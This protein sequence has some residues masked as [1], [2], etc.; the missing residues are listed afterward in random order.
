MKMLL[1][2]VYKIFAE[3]GLRS[4]S[5]LY[6][7]VSTIFSPA[8]TGITI[9]LLLMSC[10]GNHLINNKD[11]LAGTE[12]AFVFKKE[13]AANRDSDLFSVF[14]QKLSNQQSEALKF[15]YAYMPLSDLADY[16]GD[17]FL[18]NVNFSLKSRKETTWGK[19]IP[20]DIFL[21]YVLPC[22][23]NNEN[24]DS[25][26]IVYYDEIL[27]RVKGKDIR[28]AALEVNHWCHE[29]VAYQPADIRTS[30]PMS[31]ILSARGRCG[32]EST[33]TVAA[34]RT[35]GI[36]ARQVYTPRW[37]HSD[38]NHAWV[39]I[40]VKGSWYYLGACEPEPVLDRGWFTEP[41]RRAM[42]VHTKSF[43]ASPGNENVIN[44]NSD[45]STVNNL[46]KYAITKKIYVKVLDKDKALV[47]N[48]MVEFQ[49]YNYAEFYPLAVVP[50]NDH[51]ISQ[52]ETGLGDLIIWAH[53]GDKFDFRKISVVDTDTLILKL[54]DQIG[55][56]T[57]IDMDLDVPVVRSPV[58]GP[59]QM[60]IDQNTARLN[61]ENN[62][63]QNYID[64]WMK[65]EGSK[66]LALA[67]KID[68]A[69]VRSAI[70]RSMGNFREI[71]SFLSETPDS[72]RKLALSLLEIL[73][74]K[75]LRDVKRQVLTDHLMNTH[76]QVS[77]GG[78]PGDRIFLEYVLNPRIANELLVSWRHYF[79][80]KLHAQ[81]IK[82]AALDPSMII[83]YLND[84]I[85]IDDEKNY[86]NTPL[87]PVGVDK[88]KVSDQ[89]SRAICFVAMCRSLGIPA[90]LEPGRNVPQYFFNKEWND[91]Y[92]SDQKHPDLNKG[93][94]KLQSEDK[95]PVPEYYI[96]FTL[97]R[98]ENGRY[99]TLEYDYNKKITAFKEEI[100]LPPG[101]YMLVT[102]N[103][104][105]DSK[106]LSNMSFF[107]LA[108]NEHKTVD[109]KIR[110]DLSERKIL[111]HIDVKKIN[112]I[113][114]KNNT[115]QLCANDKGNVII[116]IDPDK[117]PTRHIFNDIPLLK[118]E[119]DNWGGR[120]LFLS[121]PS[122]DA[123]MFDPGNI[124]GLPSNS[125][126]AV[127]KGK[128]LLMDF[129]KSNGASEINL[130][131]V[132]VTDKDGNILFNSTGY[133]IG[134]GE[135]ILKSLR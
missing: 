92:F 38:D 65:A 31:T 59:S 120:F 104:L 60:L 93:Y 81:L 56:K 89:G 118:T 107:D 80:T 52:F 111:G 100:P 129:V 70:D 61:K 79:L 132:I 48:A 53:K 44:K 108:V 127:D 33:F 86:Y 8:A 39:E 72:L 24:L 101:H 124:K 117:E 47:S 69:R 95:S 45:Y 30:A 82:N 113:C 121:D 27:N 2:N 40:W 62:I 9:I 21:H 109:V 41:A 112:E 22:R 130:P 35:V 23:V 98:F 105:S 4:V 37:A 63:R 17:F 88:L 3:T 125:S 10:S 29:K 102:G 78:E 71:S 7:P 13:L 73:P 46:A 54:D 43:G 116:W 133:R 87:T 42:L 114:Q 135:Q 16:N 123:G 6:R 20:E 97:A 51:G 49:L 67:L 75:D 55:S 64:T 134:I 1:N 76:L 36:P 94:I 91:V 90:R 26:R 84:N 131:V 58:P 115:S 66:Q 77:P 57:S 5:M 11:Y 106:I 28:E 126:F 128:T 32:E 119:L 99:N 18:A 122:P 19:D 68:T 110:K 12:K 14:N 74:D 103:R 34:L 83:H 25:F 15:L 50:T 96:H 85:K